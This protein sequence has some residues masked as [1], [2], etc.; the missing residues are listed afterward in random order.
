MTPPRSPEPPEPPKPASE[1]A[2]EPTSKP[3]S[4]PAPKK[5][6]AF[7]KGGRP[8]KTSKSPATLS[9]T[10]VLPLVTRPYDGAV[11]DIAA[12]YEAAV[13]DFMSRNTRN[14]S[15]RGETWAVYIRRSQRPSPPFGRRNAKNVRL[16]RS[17]DI[18][19]ISFDEEIRGRGLLRRMI[20]ITKGEAVLGGCDMVLIESVVNPLLAAFLKANGWASHAIGGIGNFYMLLNEQEKEDE[21]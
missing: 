21:I 16:L 14:T 7:T 11:E 9:S 6:N 19:N 13:R 12:C 8:L 10:A 5:R 1:P 3:T 20:D 2:S 15:I 18:A 17:L 4:K